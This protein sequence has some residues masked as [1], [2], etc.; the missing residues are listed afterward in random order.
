M[1]KCGLDDNGIVKLPWPAQSPDLNPIE[2][3]WAILD[4][5]L[6]DRQPGT[7]DELFQVLQDGWNALDVDLLTRLVDSMPSR[8]QA[9]ID[10]GGFATKY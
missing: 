7:Q 8:C 9:V 5:Q 1:K 3:L 10:S 2:N 4:R 6:K